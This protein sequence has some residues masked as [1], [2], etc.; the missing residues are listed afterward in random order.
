MK[1]LQLLESQIKTL[2]KLPETGMGYQK[3]KLTLKNGEVLR[4]MTVLNSEILLIEDNQKIN[5]EN[6][7]KIETEKK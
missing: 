6:I 2:L 5:V 1:K 4:D 3:V 7:E